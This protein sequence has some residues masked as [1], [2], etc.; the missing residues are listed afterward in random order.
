MSISRNFKKWPYPSTACIKSRLGAFAHP[1]NSPL[2]PPRPYPLFPWG[3][4]PP[5]LVLSAPDLP[6]H[7]D[8]HRVPFASMFFMLQ[9]RSVLAALNILLH[10]FG[11]C[12]F[13]VLLRRFPGMELQGY[14]AHVCSAL[15]GIAEHCWKWLGPVTGP[16]HT[17][18]FASPL[19]PGLSSRLT[20][21]V[22]LESLSACSWRVGWPAKWQSA[23]LRKRTPT[24][25]LTYLSLQFS[26][27][28]KYS[29]KSILSGCRE[30]SMWGRR[31]TA[32]VRRQH[33][34]P[35]DA[36]GRWARQ[37]FQSWLWGITEKGKKAYAPLCT[38][39]PLACCCSVV[40]CQQLSCLIS[41]WMQIPVF[42][43]E[44]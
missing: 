12:M 44:D 38:P 26:V 3:D 41:F 19:W 27:S 7:A 20:L 33:C 11:T 34:H 15:A 25:S 39:L 43:G 2:P 9:V 36:V 8:V 21:P 13:A 30:E 35:S 37:F 16:F 42:Q 24:P 10:N 17:A 22:S 18:V 32:T 28:L 4:V 23:V 40:K 14:G 1:I 6:V 29:T 31:K 5:G